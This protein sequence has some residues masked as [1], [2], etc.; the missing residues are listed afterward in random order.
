MSHD[1]H[2]SRDPLL[3][4]SVGVALALLTLLVYCRCFDHPFVNFDDDIYV[5]RNS[6]VQAGLTADS[7]RWAF[8]TFACANWHP[9]TWLSLQLDTTLFGGQKAGGFHLTNVLLHTANTLLLFW[10]LNQMTAAVW[11]SALVAALFAIHPLHVES[12]AW[13]AERKDVLS[14]FFWM[15]TLAAY[16]VYVS[17]RSVT[18][19]LLVMLAL[20]LGLM[21]KPMLVT[22]P[23][24]LLLLD[25]WPLRRWPVCPGCDSRGTRLASL[26]RLVLEK[27]PLFA[28]V[29]VSCVLTFL[30]QR[31]GKAVRSFETFPLNL[32]I[33]NAL[34]TYVGYLGNLFWPVDLAVYYPHPN[35]AVSLVP[36]LGAGIFLLL[37]TILVLGL[38]RRWPYL[39]VG[40]L[41]YLG[42][43]VPVIGLV[44]VGDQ[45]MADRYT[46]V[47]LIGLFLLLTWSISDLVQAWRLPR[48]VLV[49]AG[50]VVLSGC[51]V[52]TWT[53]L[54]YWKD[55]QSLW[56]HTLAVTQKN[57]L[58][59]YN[60][61]MA[62]SELGRREEAGA[63]YRKALELDPRD[64]LAHNS[65]GIV[66]KDQ[67]R[68]PEAFDE[69]RQAIEMDA[70]FAPAHYCLG[71]VLD[72][73][74]QLEEALAEYRKAVELEPSD[75][76]SH[77]GVGMMLHRLGR[78]EEALPAFQR[79]IELDPSNALSHY[80]LGMALKNRGRQLE[81]VVE[82]R[83]ATELDPIQPHAHVAL[84]QELLELG[85]Y[86]EAETSTR[87]GLDWL[88]A[89]SPLRT[90]AIQQLERCRQL[91]AQARP[92][93]Q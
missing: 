15:I 66:L 54:G 70:Q 61:G 40:W 56:E 35:A 84:G 12:V 64:V 57:P 63:Q 3:A 49:E 20:G 7:V 81:A 85:Q 60:L 37:V 11:R 32:R 22:L 18:R 89:G 74:G 67:G 28:L 77:Y 6:H 92:Q 80:G 36:A 69:F 27:L 21:A 8:T 4:C 62:L 34:L 59:H 17:R 45:A 13:V 52:L 33:E 65:L 43:L 19:Y 16:W 73:L 88:P 44:Q 53:Q 29:L 25:Y 26:Y 78:S 41:W 55:A 30:A 39:A 38:G 71:T 75:A 50:T 46:Y 1:Q 31:Q 9:L 14:T 48:L 87:S 10:V 23:A 76:M 58:A 42:T 5:T 91:R 93:K 2:V 82:F 90:R 47:P 68:L 51:V 86:E 24:V 83:R 79:A 72:D